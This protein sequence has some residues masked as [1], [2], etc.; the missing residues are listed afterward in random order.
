MRYRVVLQFEQGGGKPC[1]GGAFELQPCALERCPVKVDCKWGD[2]S[3]LSAC[4]ASCGGGMASRS[5]EVVRLP[6]HGGKRC[7][8]N[9]T[10][11]ISECNTEACPS[12][13]RDCEFSMWND[14]QGC[15]L[16]CGGGQQ[17]RSRII[18]VEA[19]E[20][21][22][23]CKG[24]LQDFQECNTQ[25]CHAAGKLA[26]A[27][28][29]W[30]RWSACTSLCNGHQER[31]RNILTLARHGGSPCDGPE[32]VVRGCNLDSS[33]CRAE[34][35]KDCVLGPW[36][37]W[38]PCSH[39]CDGGQ[40]TRE[41]AI[42]VYPA[43]LGRPCL[44]ALAQTEACNTQ[45]CLGE[46]RY[47]CLWK[48]WED[49]EACTQS[50]DGGQRT[51]RRALVDARG[52]GMACQAGSTMEVAA[53]NLKSCWTMSEVCAWS[54]WSSYGACS[55]SCD[56]GQQT[57]MRR[58]S[59]HAP[60]VK[61]HEIARR[62]SSRPSQCLGRQK[63]IR[64]CGLT[65]CS[66][67]SA[68]VNCQWEQWN[69]WGD[70]SCSGLQSRQR[71]VAI[72]AFRG[73]VPCVGALEDSRSCYP[74]LSCT[75]L[76]INCTFGGWTSW[77]ACS[78]TCGSG[79]SFHTRTVITHAQAAGKRCDG[80]LEEVQ[81]CHLEPCGAA[82]DCV[83]TEWSSWSA[84]SRQCG[85]GQ[86]E[87]SR[88]VARPAL[89]GGAACPEADLAET[90]LCNP[91]DCIED[92]WGKIDCTWSEWSSWADCS[93]SCGQGQA[94]RTRII[95]QEAAH[96]G[97]LCKGFYQEFHQCAGRPCLVRDCSFS[98]WSSWS[99][100][101]DQ[102]T[103]HRQR[104]RSIEFPA[105]GGGEA[106]RGSTR[107]LKPCGSSHDVFCLSGGQAVDCLMTP[108]SSWSAC[109]RECGDGQHLS[110]RQVVRFAQDAGRPCE[111]A[112]R[113]VEVCNQIFCPGD[114]PV[115]C[116]LGE[117]D[118]WLPCSQSCGG[119]ERSRSRMVTRE[120]RNGGTPCAEGFT[121]Q[122]K[123]CNT[124][125][126]PTE[127]ICTWTQWAAWSECSSPCGHGQMTRNRTL[128]HPDFSSLE[129]IGELPSSF[130]SFAI[131]TPQ[132]FFVALSVATTVFHL[133]RRRMPRFRPEE[134]GYMPVSTQEDLESAQ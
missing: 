56:S 59:W 84:C 38:S 82:Q 30:T 130:L 37:T 115:D 71:S 97:E 81:S 1:V 91:Q 127:S 25:P 133:F 75:S 96:G 40:T 90:G 72:K 86:H 26:C 48:P 32:K 60:D 24:D 105:V 9:I 110:S 74:S 22:D 15:S 89:E 35:P 53:C 131:S 106:C 77:S 20:G 73:G 47:D 8:K 78:V 68:P 70:C 19:S 34:A 117:W 121:H 63:E 3:Q 99:D 114:E 101:S 44:G 119:G 120:P 62:L 11:M 109:S 10:M 6:R 122:V 16:P 104:T 33:T 100:C 124:Q 43:N 94:R 14:W 88:V 123:P 7:E 36:R 113:R 28:A 103:G 116:K 80:G 18:L 55:R 39:K 45:L 111:G 64:A 79:Q 21:G 98:V 85:G 87:R 54:D 112:L 12:T 52:H 125:H 118:F 129:A 13:I 61:D 42:K 128:F 67:A 126:C 83:Y 76:D 66:M 23:P 108:W 17:H 2:W 29:D 57:R 4:T 132:C 49:W 93:A 5:R 31:H 65:P 69:H 107:E 134:A 41:R 46:R 51:R 102:C 50:C 95:V 58:K 27:W 92:A